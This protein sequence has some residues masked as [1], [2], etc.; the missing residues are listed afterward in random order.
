MFQQSR[1]YQMLVMD[2]VIPLNQVKRQATVH[3]M[4]VYYWEE[5]LKTWKHTYREEAWS[6]PHKGMRIRNCRF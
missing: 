6:K 5:E 3:V 4:A 2:S 1:M